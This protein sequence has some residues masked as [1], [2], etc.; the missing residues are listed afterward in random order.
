MFRSP[1][2]PLILATLAAEPLHAGWRFHP[3]SVPAAAGAR[4]H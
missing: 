4:P 3:I 2:V 1:R